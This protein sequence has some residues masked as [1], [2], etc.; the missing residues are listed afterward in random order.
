ILEQ[1]KKLGCSA[2][3][4]RTTFTMD[5]HYYQS[6]MKVFVD[7]YQ[8]GWIY[9]GVRMIHW[10]V[11]AKTALSDE[12]VIYR[13]VNS[14]LY[15]VRYTVLE[16]SNIAL[17]GLSNPPLGDGGITIATVRPETILGDTA[18]CVNPKDER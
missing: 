13:E 9:R 8:K 18:I 12:E 14:K 3:W 1:L 10:D 7:L 6:V 16:E 5:E 4:T 2:D 17:H 11:K 15:Y